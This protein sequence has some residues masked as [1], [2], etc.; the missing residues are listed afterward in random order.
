[1]VAENRAVLVSLTTQLLRIAPLPVVQRFERTATVALRRRI[2]KSGFEM[3]SLKGIS[4]V[5][6]LPQQAIMR[7]YNAPWSKTLIVISA[8]AAVVCLGASFVSAWRTRCIFSWPALLPLTILVGS[9]F[10][11]VRGYSITPVAILVH[12][13]FWTTRLPL[14]GLQ[15]AQFEPEAMRGSIRTFGNGG[16]FSFTGFYWNKPL[17]SYRAFVTDQHQTVVL[18]YSA[19]TVVVSPAPAAEFVRDVNN[20]AKLPN[21]PTQPPRG[22]EDAQS[23]N[24]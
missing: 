5:R 1:M 14:A 10:F 2:H 19:R 16:C 24:R 9:T 4:T 23:A 17:R 18:R 7:S 11:T 12:R 21:H 22:T 3:A 20:A 8:L 6:Q 13:L 15:S